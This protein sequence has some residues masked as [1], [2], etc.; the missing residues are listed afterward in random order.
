MQ[1][2]FGGGYQPSR[3]AFNQM[4][5][6]FGGFNPMQQGLGG[7]AAYG[8]FGGFGGFNP[9]QGGLAGLAARG[10]FGGFGGFNP[11][12]G[13]FGGFGGFNPMQGGFGGF[14][15]MQGG[16]GGFNPMQG[17]F[18]GFGPGGNNYVAP[19]RPMVSPPPPQQ[20]QQPP[21]MRDENP[22]PGGFPGSDRVASNPYV[23]QKF[24][25]GTGL[26]LGIDVPFI[27][28]IPTQSDAPTTPAPSSDMNAMMGSFRQQANQMMQ[29]SGGRMVGFDPMIQQQR[30]QEQEQLRQQGITP[31]NP[32]D[33]TLMA[34]AQRNRQLDLENQANYGRQQ[35]QQ[36]MQQT[37]QEDPRMQAIRNLQMM[38]GGFY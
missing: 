36:M 8:G 13:G 18:G 26:R 20:P 16:F 14:N 25:P 1:G 6:G 38:R 10:G 17:G 31:I 7:L 34:A 23:P 29:P 4:Q 12:Q 21:I 9:M 15:P 37:Y 28:P 33:P 11:M 3:Q 24:Q 35:Q 30:A 2:G 32:N 22:M 27:T 5:G 19:Q